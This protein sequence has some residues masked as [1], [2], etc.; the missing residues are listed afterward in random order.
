MDFG[1]R[2]LMSASNAINKVTLT[3]ASLC[4]LAIVGVIVWMGYKIKDDSFT[5]GYSD[6]IDDTPTIVEQ[7]KEIGQW[8][9]LSISDEELVD[10]VR[11]GFFSDDELVRIYYGTMRLGIDFS[12]CD[13]KWIEREGDTIKVDLPPVRLLDENFLDETRTKSFFESGKWTNADR[14]AMAD[15]AKALMRK[16]CLTKENMDLAQ[17][18]AEAQVNAFVKMIIRKQ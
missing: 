2:K 11:R 7:M 5:I 1:L 6:K 14:K 10:T 12:Q 4:F 9:F 3:L 15:R 18:N 17:K 16:R 13:E 8:E